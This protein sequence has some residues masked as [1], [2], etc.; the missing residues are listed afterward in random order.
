MCD[1]MGMYVVGVGFTGDWD[2]KGIRWAGR[3]WIS[4]S[5]VM[6][7]RSG[8]GRVPWAFFSF[9]LFP[10]RRP[11]LDVVTVNKGGRWAEENKE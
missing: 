1:L 6:V 7:W 2:L 5:C 3:R 8:E 9:F 11:N 10:C 4:L